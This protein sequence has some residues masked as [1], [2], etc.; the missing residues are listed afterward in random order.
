[1]ALREIPDP[2]G[3]RQAKTLPA[4]AYSDTEFHD[5][6]REAIFQRDWVCAGIVDEMPAAGSFTTQQQAVCGA[7][8]PKGELSTRDAQA[9]ARV[10]APA[11]TLKPGAYAAAARNAKRLGFTRVLPAPR[12]GRRDR[13]AA[14]RPAGRGRTRT[15]REVNAQGLADLNGRISD[16]AQDPTSGRLFAAVGEGGV[17]ESDD[18]GMHWRSIGDALPTQAIGSVAYSPTGGG[19]LFALTGDSVFGGG[20]T[21]AGAGL[22]RSTNLGGSWQRANGIPD[23]VI[24]F[25]VV[26]DPA[27]PSRVYAATGAGL[28][29]STDGG[30]SFSD[31]ALPTGCRPYTSPGCFLANMVTDVAVHQTNH[32]VTAAVGWRAGN[33]PSADATPH[34]ESPGNGI[35]M[36]DTGAAGSFTKSTATGFTP[37][38]QIGRVELGNATGPKQDHDYLYAIVEDAVKFN[39][40][41]EALDIDGGNDTG[42]IPQNTALDG[43]YVSP[44]FGA[45]WKKMTRPEELALPGTGSALSGVA[46]T[47]QMYC[48]GIQAW[49]NAWVKPDPT[50]VEAGCTSNCVPTRL[51]FGLEEVWQSRFDVPQDYT[52]IPGTQNFKV[53]GPYFAGD[54][55]QF[56][57]RPG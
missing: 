54:T 50:R 37:Q 48:P 32:Q 28:F 29:R 56:T 4:S 12:R 8:E 52:G 17:W 6:E 19:T 31:V 24:A 11:T 2:P 1:M 9:S 27:T 51:T 18:V 26:A 43:V 49:Y 46:C 33:K 40:G 16:F 30:A 36:S 53:I 42:G 15:T 41:V 22:Y 47:G 38:D 35:Y 34:P 57:L 3:I 7:P 23:G 20:S 44:D 25:K 10:T 13:Q 45:T 21:Y 5:V 39:G 55:C 14:S